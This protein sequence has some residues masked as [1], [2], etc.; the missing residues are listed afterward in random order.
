MKLCQK[1]TTPDT[2]PHLYFDEE[3]VCDACH[4]AA[5]KHSHENGITWDERKRE[6]EELM[7]QYR[8]HDGSQ[9]DC[10]V[11]VSGGKDSIYQ[12]H[13]LK[14]E[15]GMNPLAVTFG[16][17]RLT[18]NGRNNL[19]ALRSIGVD[20]ISY[21]I[22]PKVYQKL[23]REGLTRVGDHCWACHIGI[24][25]V[26]VQIACRFRIPLVVY[27]ENGQMEYGGPQFFRDRKVMD[28]RWREEFCFLGCRPDAMR[29]GLDISNADLKFTKFPTQAELEKFNINTIRLGYYFKWDSKRNVEIAKSYGF[30]PHPNGPY[31]GAY[32]DFENVDCWF[33]ELHD[34]MM[35]VKY[36]FGRAT[37]QTSIDIRNGVLSRQDGI[38]IVLELDGRLSD[39]VIHDFCEWTGMPEREFHRT[40]DSFANKRVLEKRGGRWV[41]KPDII[42]RVYRAGGTHD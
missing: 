16:Q 26:P 40:V 28:D 42:E 5:K 27:G 41:R 17:C 8:C 18:D 23:G 20:H 25:T 30:L 6:F 7:D 31:A 14:K 11:P 32:W 37:T 3:N 13:F 12:T 24:H 29:Q 2:R 39:R 21:D 4:T 36:G 19:Q 35:F 9:Y 33:I 15:Y 10:V 1:C 38:E 22:N 34:Y